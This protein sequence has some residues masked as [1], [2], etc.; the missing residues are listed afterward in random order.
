MNDCNATLKMLTTLISILL[1][2]E[3]IKHKTKIPHGNSEV[4]IT[5][6][7]RHRTSG[8]SLSSL[9]WWNC[10]YFPF[11]AANVRNEKQMPNVRYTQTNMASRNP[12][13]GSSCSF[14]SV[15]QCC[16]C[17]LNN[18]RATVTLVCWQSASPH[19]LGGL[20]FLLLHPCAYSMCSPVFLPSLC[21]PK[22][23]YWWHMY[24]SCLRR[25]CI[26]FNNSKDV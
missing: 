24:L 25:G 9:S 20:P 5:K 10:I 8:I 12:A 7:H 11:L 21:P 26:S 6:H 1:E 19:I 23:H 17:R 15:W 18:N 14:S 16:P 3:L 13:G 22:Y 2:A 4:W